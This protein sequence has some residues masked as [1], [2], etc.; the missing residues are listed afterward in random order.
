VLQALR[1]TSGESHTERGGAKLEHGKELNVTERRATAL[2]GSKRLWI[3]WGNWVSAG[4]SPLWTK[5]AV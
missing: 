2:N 3:S 1:G 5:L 4:Q